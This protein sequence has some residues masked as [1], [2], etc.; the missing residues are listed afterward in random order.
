MDLRSFQ[1]ENLN[2]IVREIKE[3]IKICDAISDCIEDFSE[4]E[5]IYGKN[6]IKINTSPSYSNIKFESLNNISNGW[7]SIYRFAVTSGKEHSTLATNL[8]Q[9]IVKTLPENAKNE[10][11]A[12]NTAFT[13]VN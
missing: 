11:K 5:T 8:I 6:L 13:K 9:S 10:N 12:I 4:I 3:R 1:I 7:E 2:I